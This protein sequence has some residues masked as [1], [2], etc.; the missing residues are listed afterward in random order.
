MKTNTK[1]IKEKIRLHILESVQ[2][3][4]ENYFK[5][6]KDAATH[7]FNEFIRVER[8][9]EFKSFYNYIFG[10]PFNFYF[11]DEDIIDFLNELGIIDFLKEKHKER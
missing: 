6:A 8:L 10:L 7:L 11:W 2:D 5:T 4:E 9:D 1:E 3:Y